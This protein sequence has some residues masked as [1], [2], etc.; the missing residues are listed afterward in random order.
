M[1]R[2]AGKVPFAAVV[3]ERLD[4]L[5]RTVAHLRFLCLHADENRIDFCKITLNILSKFCAKYNIVQK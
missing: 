4:I 3:F 1:V 2:G 5:F